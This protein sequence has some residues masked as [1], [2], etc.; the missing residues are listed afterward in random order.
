[1]EPPF[2]QSG[3][4]GSLNYSRAYWPSKYIIAW[5]FD[6]GNGSYYL[7]A[8]KSASLTVTDRGIEGSVYVIYTSYHIIDVKGNFSLTELLLKLE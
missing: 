3:L 4:Q 5:N 2:L 6:V 7:F 1:M 8:S